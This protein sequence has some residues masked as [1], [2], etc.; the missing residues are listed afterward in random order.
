[1]AP[2]GGVVDISSDED[3]LIGDAL[4]PLDPHG[5]TAD[6]FDVVDNATGEDFDD[7]VIMSEISAPPVL[8][9]TAKPDD[10]VVMSELSSPPVLQKKGN[11]DGDCDEDDDDCVV[12]DGDPD[13]AVNVADEEGSARDG[14]SDEL[15]IVAE[16]GPIACRDFPH[17]RHLC[18][19][20][21]FSTTSHVKHCVMEP[22]WKLMRQVFRGCLPASGP[23]KLQNDLYSTTVSPRQQ[24][25][26]CHV[27]VPQSPPSSVLHVGYPSRAIQSPLVNEGRH[28]QQRHRSVRVSLSVG[29][30]VSSPRAGRGTCSAHIAQNIHSHAIFKRAGAVSPGFASPNASQFGSAGP[31]SSLMH[32]ALPHVSQPV[33]VAPATNAFTETAQSNP[34]QRS[35]S[36][37]IAYQAA[38]NGMDVIGPQL[39][40]CTSLITERTQCLPEPVT[41]VCTKSWEDILATVASDLGVADYDISTAESPHVMT[42]SQPVHSTANQ[43]FSLQHESVAAMENLTSS[44]MHDL[45]GHTT[46]GNVQADH[47]LET[48]ENWDHLIGGN[49][50]VSA[51]ADVLSVDEATHQLAVSRLESTDIL[52][53]LDWS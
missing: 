10:L 12:L 5:W 8:H 3:F 27:A 43:G 31:D 7:L 39:S 30:T 26:R 37:P 48:A 36:A 53:E 18:S 2:V 17:S 1:M 46:G 23:E 19:N 51:P 50:F 21:P 22:K 35:F 6:L 38:T 44:H 52:F 29:G 9:Q 14:S 42:D 45:S 16:K 33:Q 13:K 47:P 11:A 32:Q 40:R 4:A 15:Q 24:P 34:F 28:N 49:D 41:D 20:L 25:M